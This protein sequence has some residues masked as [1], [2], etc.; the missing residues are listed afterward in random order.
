M[1][2]SMVRKAPRSC[3]PAFTNVKPMTAMRRM[4]GSAVAMLRWVGVSVW[5]RVRSPRLKVAA[6]RSL[7]PPPAKRVE[8]AR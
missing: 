4:V 7:R 6:S 8:T 3:G 1:A 2:L 5:T